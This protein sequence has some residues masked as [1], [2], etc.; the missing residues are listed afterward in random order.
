M[1]SILGL[2]SNQNPLQFYCWL[3]VDFHECK[4]QLGE[5]L[6]VASHTVV[7]EMTPPDPSQPASLSSLISAKAIL[8]LGAGRQQDVS[9]RIYGIAGEG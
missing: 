1:V 4:C 9:R 7:A 3:C 5:D 6:V 2:F 8:L